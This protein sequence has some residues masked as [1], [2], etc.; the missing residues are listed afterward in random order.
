MKRTLNSLILAA[1]LSQLIVPNAFAA[2][3]QGGQCGVQGSC[4]SYQYL[5]DYNFAETCT[6]LPWVKNSTAA[7]TFVTSSGPDMCSGFFQSYVQINYNNGGQSEVYQDT[8]IASNEW[9]THW[10]AG[11]NISIN[12]PNQNSTNSLLIRVWD[13]TANTLLGQSSFYYGDDVDPNCRADALSLGTH[14]LAGHVIRV[15][16]IAY[17]VNSNTHFYLT[18]V[19]LYGS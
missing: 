14:N 15:E 19:G 17:I 16:M 8:T 2:C 5:Y 1:L 10:T 18:N 13:M 7:A 9:R 4:T 6:P 11:W 12:D 3:T